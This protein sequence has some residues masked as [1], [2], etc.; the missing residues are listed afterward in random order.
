M[1]LEPST[2][3]RGQSVDEPLLP[4]VARQYSSI[5]SSVHEKTFLS[6]F[7]R[8]AHAFVAANSMD[9][10]QLMV[11]AQHNGAPTRLLDWTSSPLT[12]L[13]FALLGVARDDLRTPVVWAL[14]ATSSDYLSDKDMLKTPFELACTKLLR[15]DHVTARVAAQSGLFSVHK[16]WDKG[17]KY[18]A[19]EDQSDFSKRLTKFSVKAGRAPFLFA[20]LN[21]LGFNFASVFPDIWGLCKHL[22][23]RYEDVMNTQY[24]SSIYN[25]KLDEHLKP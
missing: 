8:R 17:G 24:I 22:E 1:S 11:L 12:A 13:W 7:R 18:V 3:Y 23:A 5:N 19:L 4:K 10:W 21:R 16:Y 6:E 25:L 14:K 9:D 15:P 2:I 20:E